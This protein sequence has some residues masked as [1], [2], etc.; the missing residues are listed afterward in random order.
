MTAKITVKGM[1]GGNPVLHKFEGSKNK[2]ASFSVAI[3]QLKGKEKS[4]TWYQIET[5][6]GSTESVLNNV[7]KGQLIEVKGELSIEQYYSKKHDENRMKAL[8]KMD[9]FKVIDRKK[10]D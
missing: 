2:K 6:N 8:V 7:Q 4:T 5:W 10:T 1:V 3:N 9:E